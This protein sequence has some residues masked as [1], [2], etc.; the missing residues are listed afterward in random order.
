MPSHPI[1]PTNQRKLYVGATL[2]AP[3]HELF[4]RIA[5]E[6]YGCSSMALARRLLMEEIRERQH[7]LP[8]RGAPPCAGPV[9][10]HHD[11]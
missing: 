8:E 7:E 5:E 9:F 1:S 3:Q 4:R 6:L 11:A 10:S 2:P